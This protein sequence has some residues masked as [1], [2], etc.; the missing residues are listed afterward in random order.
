MSLDHIQSPDRSLSSRPRYKHV[1]ELLIQYPILTYPRFFSLN[2]GLSLNDLYEGM[3]VI[4]S[5]GYRVKRIDGK[6]IIFNFQ[7]LE[8]AKEQVQ[9][10]FTLDI[11]E[12][13]STIN[14]YAVGYLGNK[15]Y[16]FIKSPFWPSSIQNLAL[17]EL[18][19]GSLEL[20]EFS[21]NSLSFEV[22]AYCIDQPSKV[23]T[24]LELYNLMCRLGINIEYYEYGAIY[25]WFDYCTNFYGVKFASIRGFGWGLMDCTLEED[26][27]EID[28]ANR[29]STKMESYLIE[30]IETI[31]CS[32]KGVLNGYTFYF[33]QL[34][35]G[36][37]AKQAYV[38]VKDKNG[39]IRV[40]NLNMQNTAKRMLEL[41]VRN[42]GYVDKAISQNALQEEWWKTQIEQE[43][44]RAVFM[45]GET[46]GN[47]K[48][49]D[50]TTQDGY[51]Y[52][53]KRLASFLEENGLPTIVALPEVGYAI[54]GCQNQREQ[55]ITE[56]VYRALEPYALS[57]KLFA[58]VDSG[59]LL[60]NI[61]FALEDFGLII[62]SVEC[63]NRKLKGALHQPGLRKTHVALFHRNIYTG[64]EVTKIYVAVELT[65]IQAEALRA[66]R[67]S[68]KIKL[69]T[70]RES[71]NYR[72]YFEAITKAFKKAKLGL[73]SGTGVLEGGFATL[74]IP[75]L[76]ES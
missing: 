62:C 9:A 40:L 69:P 17:V 71:D 27:Q 60:E 4:A 31:P 76:G 24:N 43:L 26:E 49:A 28:V 7:N 29:L 66:F 23:I 33:P 22:L 12:L 45:N 44:K 61:R 58:G 63:L 38:V 54:E 56:V 50:L 51:E 16:T 10:Q 68:S 14:P 52:A 36:S 46:S 65:G 21:E 30:N 55:Y 2:T 41:F 74:P 53:I 47:L 6:G 13:T 11:F 15:K 5:K 70:K 59:F 73:E 64:D 75:T 35:M 18:E 39:D 8:D 1:L 34:E 72:R 19:D 20:M 67:Y 48:I 42:K 32:T 37:L 25:R 57:R 3:E